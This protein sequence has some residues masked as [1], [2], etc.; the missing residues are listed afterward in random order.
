MKRAMFVFALVSGFLFMSAAAFANP[1]LLKK[2]DGY[3]DE[4]KKATTSVGDAAGLKG[5]ED[6]PK[7]LKEQLKSADYG[8]RAGNAFSDDPRQRKHPGYPEGGVTESHIKNA[9]KVNAAASDQR[10]EGPIGPSPLFF[11][12]IDHGSRPP[13]GSHS[14][15]LHDMADGR[16]PVTGIFF[17]DPARTDRHNAPGLDE[18]G[19]RRS[20]GHRTVLAGGAAVRFEVPLGAVDGSLY[21]AVS[22]TPARMDSALAGGAGRRHYRN[23]F[24]QP[25]GTAGR[26][27]R[28]RRLDLVFQREPGHRRGRLSDGP[29]GNR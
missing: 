28:H 2:H 13:H 1:A 10:G 23:G 3:P 27:G 18:I 26:R 16:H 20:H 17:R 25:C 14:S 8:D 21:P 29:G 12:G 4:T 11:D 7:V 19:R 5:A 22:G 24:H 6:A 15:R 9:T